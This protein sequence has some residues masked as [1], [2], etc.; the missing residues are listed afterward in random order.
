MAARNVFLGSAQEDERSFYRRIAA[1]VVSE[2][3]KVPQS[4]FPAAGL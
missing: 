4:K 1:P 2:S 3:E